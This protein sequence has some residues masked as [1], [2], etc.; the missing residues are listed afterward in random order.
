MFCI[1]VYPLMVFT[2]RAELIKF[3]FFLNFLAKSLAQN[4]QPLDFCDEDLDCV[5]SVEPFVAEPCL[6]LHAPAMHTY[7]HAT[8]S[9]TCSWLTCSSL[10]RTLVTL[11]ACGNYKDIVWWER[12]AHNALQLMWNNCGQCLEL[13]PGESGCFLGKDHLWERDHQGQKPG[14]RKGPAPQ[15][16]EQPGGWTPWDPWWEGSHDRYNSQRGERN[17]V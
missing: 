9:F 11:S 17:Q 4:F 12:Y 16:G 6:S 3:P 10:M 1:P 5:T 7:F 8:C 13:G 15:G 14:F 2:Y